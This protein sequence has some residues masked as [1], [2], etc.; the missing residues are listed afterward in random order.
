MNLSC[1]KC[2]AN[3]SPPDPENQASSSSSSPTFPLKCPN[4]SRLQPQPR[5]TSPPNYYEILGLKTLKY[6]VDLRELSSVAKGL[7]RQLH[8]DLFRQ[9]D[10]IE[11]DLSEK[12]SSLVNKAIRTFQ[13]PILRGQYLL[14]LKKGSKVDL[15]KQELSDPEFLG[16][17]MELNERLEEVSTSQ[18]WKDFRAENQEKLLGLEME[19]GSAFDKDDLKEAQLLLNKMKFYES[20][21]SRLKQ[22][23]F[24]FGVV[25]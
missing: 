16:D 2:Q 17:V 23:Q 3:I 12:L 25:D 13:D 5:G 11:R 18:E 7:Q 20:L 4:C 1:W 8:P 15:E 6:E 9:R 24:K 10:E 19:L 21:Q 14:E 22:L